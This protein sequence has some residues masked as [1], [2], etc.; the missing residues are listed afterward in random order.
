MLLSP[1]NQLLIRK[2]QDI[3]W[4]HLAVACEEARHHAGEGRFVY[5][6]TR[7][8]F[9]MNRRAKIGTRVE[10]AP[11]PSGPF[12]DRLRLLGVENADGKLIALGLILAAHPTSVGSRHQ[13][14]ADFVGAWRDAFRQAKGNRITPFFL[15]GCGGDARPAFTRSGDRWRQAEFEELPLMGRHLLRETLEVLDKGLKPIGPPKIATAASQVALPCE[16]RVAHPDSCREFL[17][18]DMPWKREFARECLRRFDRGEQL[19]NHVTFIVSRLQIAE[20]FS[21]FGLAC[22]PLCALG[23]KIEKAFSR[24][25]SIILGYTNGCFGY[26]PETGELLRG[27]YESEFYQFLPLSGP[28]F[29]GVEDTVISAMKKLA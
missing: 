25:T 18:S 2:Y 16:E 15:Q 28:F 8:T 24:G 29:P 17:Q 23:W 27:G 13:F 19:P 14:T 7:T 21:L 5:G 26:V 9:P 20:D 12:D 6:E 10:N 1:G 22:E 4:E 3:L 11:N